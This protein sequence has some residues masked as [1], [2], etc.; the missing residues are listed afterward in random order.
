VNQIHRLL[1]IFILEG[2]GLVSHLYI[3]NIEFLFE[4]ALRG[5]KSLNL[6]FGVGGTGRH[7]CWGGGA[8]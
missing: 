2:N 4:N 1:F 8:D 5:Q 3:F 7:R 6:L